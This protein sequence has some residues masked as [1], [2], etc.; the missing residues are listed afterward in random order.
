MLSTMDT[1]KLVQN[2]QLLNSSSISSLFDS[3]WSREGRALQHIQSKSLN[4]WIVV[5]LEKFQQLCL[6][7]ISALMTACKTFGKDIIVFDI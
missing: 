5:C 7:F 1:L 4:H 6:N 3:D 2:S